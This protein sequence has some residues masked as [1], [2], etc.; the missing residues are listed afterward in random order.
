MA[1]V[2]RYIAGVTSG[3]ST[4]QL[5][6]VAIGVTE[7]KGKLWIAAADH[8]ARMATDVGLLLQALNDAQLSDATPT[9]IN[10]FYVHMEDFNDA[11]V[12]LP[13]EDEGFNSNAVRLTFQTTVGGVPALDS[14]VINL[15]DPDALTLNTD[16]KSYD[17]T[18]SPFA[19]IETQLIATG[20]SKFGTAIT[21]LVEAVPN[22]V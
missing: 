12:H 7:A 18:A 10:K 2:A 5:R 3:D 17:I 16:G 1:Y 11:Y 22:D 6:S 20:R 21:A 15:R 9:A 19:N 4:G 14:I 13:L 8:A